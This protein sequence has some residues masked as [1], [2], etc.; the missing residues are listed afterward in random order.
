M[1][2]SVTFSCSDEKQEVSPLINL[3]VFFAAKQE[4]KVRED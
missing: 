3:T 1:R 2:E 4:A